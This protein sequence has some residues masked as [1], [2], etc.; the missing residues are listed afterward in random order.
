MAIEMIEER[1]GK[2]GYPYFLALE[3]DMV[4]STILQVAAARMCVTIEF[5]V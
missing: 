4:T 1:K 2:L 3:S 5:S